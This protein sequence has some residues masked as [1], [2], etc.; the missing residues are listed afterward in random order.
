[1]KIDL[2]AQILDLKGEALDPPMT[3]RDVCTMALLST[4]RDDDKLNGPQKAD[5]FALALRMVDATEV[6]LKVEDVALLKDR[7]GRGYPPITVGRA[8]AL[9]D[10]PAAAPAEKEAATMD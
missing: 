7:I 2:T 10:P 5:L 6:D 8:Y 4:L 3:L 1:M 9:L